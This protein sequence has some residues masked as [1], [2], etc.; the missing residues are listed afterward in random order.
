MKKTW[1]LISLL[2]FVFSCDV[3]PQEI[4]YGSDACHFCKMT[5]VD[6]KHAAQLVTEKGKSFKYDAIECMLNHLNEWD[7][8][9]VK[10]YLV[11]DYANPK[12]L[13]DASSANYLMSEA[14]PSP[15]GANLTA[16]ENPIV[17]EQTIQK[18]GGD[19]LNWE[20]LQQGFIKQ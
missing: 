11:T 13:I 2:V 12:V 14:I 6:T 15:M 4:A 3:K 7:Q 1:L 16:F 8:A 19:I 17:R 20:Q 5:I 18:S 10:Y 9:P